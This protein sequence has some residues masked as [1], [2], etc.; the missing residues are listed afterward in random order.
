MSTIHPEK[1]DHLIRQIRSIREASRPSNSKMGILARDE[2]TRPMKEDLVSQ[3][4]AS[5]GFFEPSKKGMM[6]ATI[7]DHS[8]IG[9]TDY[10]AVAWC[11]DVISDK[12]KFERDPA[13]L[14]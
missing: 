1:L 2:M 12:I 14:S 13:V 7:G 11:L 4:V 6:K 5:G 3:F 10:Q 9:E 8:G